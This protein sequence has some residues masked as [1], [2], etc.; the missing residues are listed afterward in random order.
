MHRRVAAGLLLYTLALAGIADAKAPEIYPLDQVKRGQKGYGLTVFSGTTPERFEF[1]VISVMK[2][3]LP[4]MSIVL[5][6][7]DDPKITGPGFAQG[8]SGSPLFLDGKVMCA[9]SYA[10]RFNRIAMGGCTPI[11]NM[12]AD[13]KTPTRGP[14]ATAL[15]SAAE[16]GRPALL[17]D[18]TG[19]SRDEPT[20]WLM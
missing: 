2:N 4:R 17:D 8:M 5:V 20:A 3:F 15:A 19:G 18:F 16:W 13:G 6:K 9:F 10:F 7:S 1:E 12:L 14:D 11:G